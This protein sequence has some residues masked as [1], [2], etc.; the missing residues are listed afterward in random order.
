MRNT[1]VT[2]PASVPQL[3]KSPSPN[4]NIRQSCPRACARNNRTPG[5][6]RNC[7]RMLDRRGK[8]KM[9][10]NDLSIQNTNRR[11]ITKRHRFAI[12][13]LFLEGVPYARCSG[14]NDEQSRP[15]LA[16]LHEVGDWWG[17]SQASNKHNYVTQ[18]KCVITIHVQSWRSGQWVWC[19]IG[20]GIW[21]VSWCVWGFA[22]TGKKGDGFSNRRWHGIHPTSGHCV[23]TLCQE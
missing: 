13:R 20:H 11:H 4:W 22:M 3:V 17:D 18:G 23:P 14:Y 15:G 5:P 21:T 7:L 9:V 16:H 6:L 19:K 12:P 1:R 2:D 10:L 8:S